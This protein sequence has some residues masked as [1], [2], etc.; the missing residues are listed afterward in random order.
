MDISSNVIYMYIQKC[1]ETI[2]I[3]FPGLARFRKLWR[4]LSNIKLPD[5]K[6]RTRQLARA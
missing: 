2:P 6:A 1:V 5:G 3:E 4:G